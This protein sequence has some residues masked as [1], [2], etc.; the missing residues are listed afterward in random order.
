MQF[1]FIILLL[2]MMFI[3]VLIFMNVIDYKTVLP[4]FTSALGSFFGAGMAFYIS[5]SKEK[6]D[7]IKKEI[8]GANKALFVIA[9]QIET[10]I[11]M[12]KMTSSYIDDKKNYDIA[13]MKLPAIQIPDYSDLKVD[14]AD[15]YMFIG[16]NP[17]ILKKILA[18]QT[19]FSDFLKLCKNRAEFYD[20]AILPLVESNKLKGKNISFDELKEVFGEM[21]YEKNLSFTKNI[22][23]RNGELLDS[24]NILFSE[25]R[26]AMKHK[27]PKEK[28][29]AMETS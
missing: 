19:A 20:S 21:K 14:M 6:N 10:F 1:I 18:H 29:I 27:Y 17:D 3:L 4:I 9:A 22:Y 13:A 11:L 16:D 12:Q 15:L 5:D 23:V 26:L 25:V 28:F 7:K 24:F 8:D 2:G